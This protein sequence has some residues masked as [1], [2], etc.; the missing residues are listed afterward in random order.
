VDLIGFKVKIDKVEEG[1]FIDTLLGLENVSVRTVKLVA[2]DGTQIELLYFR[3]HTNLPFWSGNPYATGLTHIALNVIDIN[4]LVS[5]LEQRGYYKINEIQKSIDGKVLVCYLKGF[6]DT[7][8]E[9]VQ[10]L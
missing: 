5:T 3:S 7:L 10:I 4:A 6:E 1:E 8:L 2:Q 9:L